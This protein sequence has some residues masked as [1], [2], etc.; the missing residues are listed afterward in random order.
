MQPKK[1]Y[2]SNRRKKVL[3][4]NDFREVIVLQDSTIIEQ[5]ILILILTAVKF[6]QNNFI[7][8]RKQIINEETKQLS[9]DDN[10]DQ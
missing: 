10:F 4:S 8:K 7:S 3:F 6:E 1:V 9:F 2:T 5:R